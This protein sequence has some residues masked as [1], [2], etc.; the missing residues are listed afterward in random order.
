GCGP[1]NPVEGDC[2]TEAGSG[3]LLIRGQIL[4]PDEVLEGGSVLIGPSG[5]IECVGCDC[6]ASQGFDG[7]S[8]V[9]CPNAVVSPGLLNTHDHITYT[10][11]HPAIW[12]EERFDHRH[13][14]R[15]GKRGHT[16]IP[17]AGRASDDEIIWGEI[18]QLMGGATSLSGSGS[19]S[20]FLRN[21]DRR[22][23]NEGL[24]QPEVELDTF[25]FD[26]T[27]GIFRVGS[28]DYPAVPNAAVLNNESWSPHVSEGID[29]EAR[30]E[31]LCLATDFIGGVDVTEEN[32]AYIHAVGLMAMDAAV[33]ANDHTKIIWSARTNISLYGNTAPVTLLDRLGVTIGLGTDWTPSGSINMLRELV[34]V[35]E[36]NQ[37]QFDG[38]FTDKQIWEMA[39]LNNARALLLDDALGA[40]SQGLA[41]DVAIF[42]ARGAATPYREIIEASVGDTLLVLRSGEPLYGNSEIVSALPGTQGC[43]SMGDV[44]G[45]VKHLCV[46]QEIQKSFAQ[47]RGA[48]NGS[49]DLFFC[50]TPRDEPT[51]VPSRPGEYSGPTDGD[52]D[53]D[54]LADADDNCPTVF[55]PIR[56]MDHGVQ[57]DH[58]RDGIGDACDETPIGDDTPGNGDYDGDGAGDFADNCPFASNGGQE[59]ADGDQI[60]D[61]CDP[62]PEAANPNFGPCPSTIYAVKRGEVSEGQPV[63]VEGVITAV[64]PDGHFFVQVHESM[65]EYTGVEDSGIYT[66]TGR[67]GATLGAAVG[68][69][70]RVSGDAGEYYGQKQLSNVRALEVISA[71]H[72]LPEVV[73]LTTA[74]L[75]DQAYADGLEGVR[76]RVDDVTVTEVNPAPGAGDSAPTEELVLNGTLRVGDFMFK[77]APLPEVGAE[78]GF[79]YGNLRW[80]NGMTKL[81]PME[82]AD[83]DLGPAQIATLGPEGT[84][85]QLGAAG[86]PATAEG[87]PLTLTL[88]APAEDGGLSVTLESGDP[89]VFTVSAVTVP[90]GSRAIGVSVTPVAAGSALL[91]ARVADRGEASVIVRVIDGDAPPAMLVFEPNAITM[92]PGQAAEVRVRIDVPAM[93]GGVQVTLAPWGQVSTPRSVTIPEGATSAP[94]TVTAENLG[95]SGVNASYGE[96]TA[97]LTVSVVERSGGVVINEINYDMAGD[98]NM[99]FIEIYNGS[100]SEVDLTGWVLK[101]V[102]GSNGTQYKDVTLSGAL[103]SGGYLVWGDAGVGPLEGATFI[104][105]AQ[106]AGDGHDVQNG[107]TPQGDGVL[108][109]DA[110]GDVLDAV[111]Y[112]GTVAN[113]NEGFAL[114]DENDDSGQ[115]INRCPNGEDTD[116]NAADFHTGAASPGAANSCD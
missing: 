36:L 12:G 98:E 75:E 15:R 74:A 88:T 44:C 103:P 76:V 53:G 106:P 19:A 80:A 14:W 6:S 85:I 113:F 31:L 95:D 40:L 38:Y 55:N 60:G 13:D 61:L 62:C 21:V 71:N 33:L 2:Y 96:L 67:E 27:D 108:L 32:S 64:H 29:D 66:Y 105:F 5:L 26:D 48:N 100:A 23:D 34:C 102:N 107:G 72:A 69:R 82:E 50:E 68:Q 1:L 99:E 83:F 92:A 101:L 46:Q 116:D 43:E 42:R 22:S 20:G 114:T 57:G 86:T 45:T 54:G 10:Q 47:L 49:Y 11:N 84:L 25:P 109:L 4:T 18:R 73:V 59:D 37:N 104:P 56:P 97:E 52:S 94:V 9:Y 3:Y 77:L 90:A 70:V 63:V 89:D 79:I 115:S 87:A 28:C 81:E 7:A 78:F 16:E 35:D 58:D 51:C 65:S 17:A 112:E 93:T 91:T 24:A 111:A 41:A 39:T 110:A 30:N 8:V